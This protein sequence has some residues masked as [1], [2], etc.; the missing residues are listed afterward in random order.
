M[1]L[2]P[3]TPGDEAADHAELIVALDAGDLGGADLDRARALSVSCAGCATLLGDLAAIRGALPAFPVPPR[4]RDY[5]LT[6]E[7]A[8]RLRPTGWRRMLGWL[9]A[10]GST[11]RPLA[12]G[13]ATLGVV[14]LLLTAGL[15]GLGAGG[16]TTSS[17]AEERLEAPAADGAAQ[18]E[19]FTTN[20]PALAPTGAPAPVATA[21]PAP[22]TSGTPDGAGPAVAAPGESP[23][24]G[25]ERN[26]TAGAPDD[27]GDAKLGETAVAG[28]DGPP[29]GLLAS[30][31]L[32]ASGIALFVARA[33]ALRRA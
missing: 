14:G 16:A 15:P 28:G 29:L 25:A 4:R 11:V 30:L 31:A 10:P 7:D 12:T 26:V 33:L 20:G 13:L 5:R 32:L 18:A 17:S 6:D 19:D 2:A 8:A 22:V 21:A 1:P 24:A 9:A 23:D 27:A 3:H